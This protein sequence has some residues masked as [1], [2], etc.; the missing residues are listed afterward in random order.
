MSFDLNIQ[1]A[2][3]TRGQ[4]SRTNSIR[5]DITARECYVCRD[6][7]C[8]RV[9]ITCLHMFCQ[10]CVETWFRV[11]GHTCPMCRQP[12]VEIEHIVVHP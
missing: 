12:V 7:T 2:N 6:N 8:D 1:S 11:H 9:L 5:S 4:L 3:V 10:N